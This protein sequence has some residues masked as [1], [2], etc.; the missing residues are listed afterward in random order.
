MKNPAWIYK[1]NKYIVYSRIFSYFSSHRCGYDITQKNRQ[2]K[3]RTTPNGV[4]PAKN[5]TISKKKVYN[6][7][8][9]YMNLRRQTYTAASTPEWFTLRRRNIILAA[10][11]SV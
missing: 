2:I 3:Q 7:K 9:L 11:I 10:S 1:T 4:F 8:R 6:K 5:Y